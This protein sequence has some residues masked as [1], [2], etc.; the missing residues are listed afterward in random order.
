[1]L[2][3][4]AL[5]DALAVPIFPASSLRFSLPALQAAA[6]GDYGTIV[7]RG[8]RCGRALP[9]AWGAMDLK[10]MCCL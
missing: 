1:V 9:L 8:A 4:Y 3:I 6:R 7:G 2:A 5:A 10:D